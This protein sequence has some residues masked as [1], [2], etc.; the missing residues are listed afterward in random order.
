MADMLISRLT[1]IQQN[2]PAFFTNIGTAL[3]TALEW[4]FGW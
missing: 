2:P 3:D 4:L 1:R